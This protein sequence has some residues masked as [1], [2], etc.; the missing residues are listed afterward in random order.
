MN[1]WHAKFI[2][3]TAVRTIIMYFQFL[4]EIA[5]ELMYLK[6]AKNSEIRKEK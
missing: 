5:S 1:V 3:I 6:G 2:Q 4:I